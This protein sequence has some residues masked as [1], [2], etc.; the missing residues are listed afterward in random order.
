MVSEV[1]AEKHRQEFDIL[2]VDHDGYLEE[3]DI[4]E[5]ATR[6]ATGA[7]AHD[8]ELVR[9]AYLKFWNS[10]AFMLR[11]SPDDRITRDQYIEGIDE[12]VKSSPDGFD[13]AIA[14]IPRAILA[15]YDHDHDGRL[16]AK[17]FL[18]M[19][20]AL[21]VSP[22]HSQIA[23]LALDRDAD[24]FI[25]GTDLIRATRE[26]EL[27]DDPH[28]PGNWLLGGLKPKPFKPY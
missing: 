23:L 9:D 18:A 21:G 4:E 3:A 26:F 1:S 22:E 20:A 27:S 19:Q 6:L 8:V 13:H 25:D 16:S 12:I 11:I 14:Q 7:A 10:L 17:E 15:L 24:G 5:I 28:A 2:D